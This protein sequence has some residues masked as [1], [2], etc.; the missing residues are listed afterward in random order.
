MV[1]ALLTSWSFLAPKISFFSCFTGFLLLIGVFLLVL[2][3]LSELVPSI[4]TASIEKPISAQSKQSK[5][6]SFQKKES[7]T[8]KPK[9]TENL[10]IPFKPTN[11]K[12][13]KPLKIINRNGVPCIEIEIKFEPN[14]L[15]RKFK[16]TVRNQNM[17]NK[18][19]SR[20]SRNIEI[21]TT[22]PLFV[23]VNPECTFERKRSLT[24]KEIVDFINNSSPIINIS[25]THV[26]GSLSTLTTMQLKALKK[27]LAFKE[28]K[29]R[30]ERIINVEMD[31][32]LWFN[33][34]HFLIEV[35]PKDVE[36]F[37]IGC[38]CKMWWGMGHQIIRERYKYNSTKSD[39]VL[40]YM[41]VTRKIGKAKSC[42]YELYMGEAP[43][44]ISQLTAEKVARIRFQ[45]KPSIS[46]KV[47]KYSHNCYLDLFSNE[48]ITNYGL[49][50]FHHLV[51]L[52]ISL[53]SK[54]TNEALKI[55]TQLET[56]NLW[57]N[58]VITNKSVKNLTSLTCLVLDNNEKI[59]DE[60]VSFLT[61]LQ[62]L[63]LCYNT[64]ITDLSLR[65]LKLLKSLDLEKNTRISNDGLKFCTQLEV[66]HLSS[67][68]NITDL[69]IIEM[70][71]SLTSLNLSNNRTISNQAVSVLTNLKKLDLEKNFLITDSGMISYNL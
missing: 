44:F 69:A 21:D 27:C 12:P 33:I 54:I 57:R 17:P 42:A 55:M 60:A 32:N 2:F 31:K 68:R 26:I 56:L 29:Y 34:F 24:L 38:V 49:R 9:I 41:A 5:L 35:D 52:N 59:T 53:N 40:N 3:L 61:N 45:D 8:K 46:F 36:L 43:L 28:M 30:V 15:K 62:E 47:S 25:F 11:T 6:I 65:N 19:Q 20:E 1:E 4:Y 51:H 10:K 50:N 63:S 67:N 23:G 13:K 64:I 18:R 58:N 22:Q 7:T 70:Q 39:K 66:L 16:D 14:P 71:K 48:T 37:K